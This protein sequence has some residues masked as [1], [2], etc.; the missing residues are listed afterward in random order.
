MDFIDE[1]SVDSE[2]SYTRRLVTVFRAF[3]RW[4]DFFFF[5]IFFFFSIIE[6]NGGDQS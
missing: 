3:A 4:S 5:L 1:E 6:L 2:E